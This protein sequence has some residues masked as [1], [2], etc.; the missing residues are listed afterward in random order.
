MKYY[1]TN[2]SSGIERECPP[3]SVARYFDLIEDLT[4]LDRSMAA[5]IMRSGQRIEHP[6][7][8]FRP[9]MAASR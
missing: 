9:E 7:Y 5:M 3:E 2:K 4:G 8:S 1:V 6:T